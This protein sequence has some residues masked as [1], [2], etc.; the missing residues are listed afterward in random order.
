MAEVLRPE[1]LDISNDTSS[2]ASPKLLHVLAVDD[3]M[4]DRKF[5]ER[6]LRVSSCKVTVVDSATRALQYLG[7]DGENNSS[8]GFEVINLIIVFNIF[9]SENPFKFGVKRFLV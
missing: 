5:I 1:M 9:E 2:L 6:L 4:V 8:V 7:L 3:S